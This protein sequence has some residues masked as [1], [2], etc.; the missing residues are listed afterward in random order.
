MSDLVSVVA[1]EHQV[2]ASP[3]PATQF[4]DSLKS[5]D[6]CWVLEE[7]GQVRGFAIYAVVLDE[8]NLLNVAIEPSQQGGGRGRQL[9][10][11]TLLLL[12]ERG[13]NNC[14]LEVRPS[15]SRALSLYQSLGFAQVGLRKEYYPNGNG[16]EDAKV[17]A[18]DLAKLVV[19][20]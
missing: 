13:V 2:N 1:I 19:P 4:A 15:N 16:R 6:L 9:V 3:W 18:V 5:K 14:F 7:E 10:T 8:A 20:Q 12:K 17:M 11:A